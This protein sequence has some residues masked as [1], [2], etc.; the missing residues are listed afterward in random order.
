LNQD[1]YTF[2]R[3]RSRMDG[4]QWPLGLVLSLTLHALVAAAFVVRTRKAESEQPPKVTWVTLPAAA[5]GGELGG[6]GPLEEGEEGERL[7]R[8]EEV[9]PHRDEPKGFEQVTPNAFGS[10]KTK[11]I[12]GTSKNPDSMGKAP[13]AS[14]GKAPNPN[15][16]PGSAGRGGGGGIGTATGIPGLKA[17]SGVQGGTGLIGDLEGD[18]PFLWYLQQVQARITGNWNRLTSAQGRVQIYFRIR[19]DGS[20]EGARVEIPSGNTGLD[21]SA[22]L[23]VRRSDPLPRLP[24]GFEGRTLGV[25]FWFTYVGN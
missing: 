4:R 5:G 6:S 18:F 7:R 3:Q 14:K 11:P 23:A 1:L 20:L 16:A 25:R 10:R 22:L 24:E 2:L 8:V 17:S 21:Q 19:R 13:V 9:A 12:Q 15:S